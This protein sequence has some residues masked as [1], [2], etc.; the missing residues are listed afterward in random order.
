MAI[1]ALVQ[2]LL[3][4]HSN[5]RHPEAVE[6][7]EGDVHAGV[8]V[9]ESPAAVLVAP[10]PVVD[11][12][13]LPVVVVT[14]VVVVVE[15]PAAV[16]VAPLPVVLVESLPVVVVTPGVVVVESPAVVLV[17]P[18][19]VVDVESLPVVVVTLVPGV[20]QG[21]SMIRSKRMFLSYNL[22]LVIP[23]EYPGAQSCDCGILPVPGKQLQSKANGQTQISPLS[24]KLKITD[25]P[26]LYIL[27]S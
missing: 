25:P 11:V 26:V 21:V 14:P 16:L 27:K 5:D 6:W 7:N 24:Q 23:I 17:A 3:L 20:S 12:E 1:S 19:P 2:R 13:S 15:S 8:V 18:L 22:T 10:L 9:V 4:V